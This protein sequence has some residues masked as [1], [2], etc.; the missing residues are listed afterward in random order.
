MQLYWISV[1]L[2]RH[3]PTAMLVFSINLVL[4]SWYCLYMSWT[5]GKIKI[6]IV[7][8]IFSR[9]F[10]Q[11]P[12][13]ICPGDQFWHAGLGVHI[14]CEYSFPVFLI[15]PGWCHRGCQPHLFWFQWKPAPTHWPFL[16]KIGH[17]WVR[18][19][20]WYFENTAPTCILE[21]PLGSLVNESKR[22][23]KSGCF[24]RAWSV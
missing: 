4:L 9:K 11:Q 7:C 24:R 16:A 2:C 19:C 22:V 10:A 18:G 23:R 14:F 12:V 17:P 13:K 21:Q 3:V 20:P 1:V 8:K 6:K 15:S 5:C